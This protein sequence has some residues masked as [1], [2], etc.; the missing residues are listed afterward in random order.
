LGQL[1]DSAHLLDS[2][3]GDTAVHCV[4]DYLLIRTL[5]NALESQTPTPR[6]SSESQCSIVNVVNAGSVASFSP[7]PFHSFERQLTK[8]TELVVGEISTKSEAATMRS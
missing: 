1:L 2:F 7:I 4:T 5:A 3:V 6:L 8:E